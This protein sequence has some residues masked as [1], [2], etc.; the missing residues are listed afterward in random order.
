MEWI[1]RILPAFEDEFGSDDLINQPDNLLP[2]A[3]NSQA[4]QVSA[5]MTP[6]VEDFEVKSFS[7]V[8]VIEIVAE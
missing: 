2:E 5:E 1:R 7:V 3:F 8:I 4:G 6:Q